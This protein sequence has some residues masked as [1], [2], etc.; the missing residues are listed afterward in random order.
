MNKQKLQYQQDIGKLDK[1]MLTDEQF[2]LA[3]LV[4]QKKPTADVNT[5]GRASILNKNLNRVKKESPLKTGP[6]KKLEKGLTMQQVPE[7]M[8]PKKGLTTKGVAASQSNLHKKKDMTG[9]ST[10]L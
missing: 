4:E 2:K 5:K 6:T 8:E 3:G 1:T 9:R 7:V 10:A